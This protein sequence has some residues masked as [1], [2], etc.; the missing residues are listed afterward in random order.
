MIGQCD[1]PLSIHMVILIPRNFVLHA[2]ITQI[3]K[4]DLML[5]GL[6]DLG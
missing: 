2:R 1:T 5:G 3:S 4:S 6:D